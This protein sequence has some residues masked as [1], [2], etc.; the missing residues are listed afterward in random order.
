LSGT[1]SLRGGL[2]GKNAANNSQLIRRYKSKIK[3]FDKNF[4]SIGDN[5]VYFI[6]KQI[7]LMRNK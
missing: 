1:K 6:F 5:G 3:G 4:K 2:G 7:F